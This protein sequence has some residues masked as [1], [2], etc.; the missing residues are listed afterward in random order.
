[1]IDFKTVRQ[2]DAKASAKHF[3]ALRK[4]PGINDLYASEAVQMP[5]LSK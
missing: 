4:P 1:V 5:L 3:N 2:A